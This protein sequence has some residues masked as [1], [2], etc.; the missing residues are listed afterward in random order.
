MNVVGVPVARPGEIVI[1][2][3]LDDQKQASHTIFV[4][5]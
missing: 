4:T 3:L 1:A 2:L 5:A